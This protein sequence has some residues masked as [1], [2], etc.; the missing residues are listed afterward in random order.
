MAV[1][2]APT[3]TAVRRS[4][5]ERLREASN[6]SMPKTWPAA[7]PVARESP[8]TSAGI[9]SAEAPISENRGEIA[10]QGLAA[11][12]RLARRRTRRRPRGA[13]PRARSRHW[14]TRT[15]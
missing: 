7:A 15:S 14:C 9:D 4:D 1:E 10:E 3:S 5:P 13:V 11:Y 8:D 2:S 6:A 12:R